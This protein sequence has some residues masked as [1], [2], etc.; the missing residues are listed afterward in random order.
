MLGDLGKGLR[1]LDFA[2][3]EA[4]RKQ[5]YIYYWIL[6]LKKKDYSNAD[7]ETS[8]E[9]GITP[10]SQDRRVFGHF[11]DLDNFQGFPVRHN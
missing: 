10:V 3:L 5:G 8:K 2:S 11:C 1:N 7:I 4:I 6:L 9:A